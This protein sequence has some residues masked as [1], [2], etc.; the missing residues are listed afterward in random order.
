MDS[1]ALGVD[2]SWSDLRRTE[3]EWPCPLDSNSTTNQRRRWRFMKH[4]ALLLLLIIPTL[5]LTPASS[6]R[7]ILVSRGFAICRIG[8]AE[9]TD[10]SRTEQSPHRHRQPSLISCPTHLVVV[11]RHRKQTAGYSINEARPSSTQA[12][13][14]LPAAAKQAGS[15]AR[16]PAVGKGWYFLHSFLFFLSFPTF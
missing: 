8:R 16:E 11:R 10:R 12:K 2:S 6:R 7:R 9:V 1:L 5:T 13:A 14:K 4:G 3:D 15:W